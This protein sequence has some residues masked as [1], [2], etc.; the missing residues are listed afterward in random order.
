MSVVALSAA[1]GVLAAAAAY[2]AGRLGHASSRAAD[3]T[4]WLG[5]ALIVIPVAHRLLSRKFLAG[6]EAVSLVVVLT[7][8]E[9]LLKICYSPA[10]FTFVDEL[11]HWRSAVNLLHTGKLFTLNYMLPIS[12]RY[13]GLEEVTSALTSLTGLSVFASG[14]IVAGV[15]HL[16][17]VCLL[18][19]LFHHIGGRRLAGVAVLIYA[20]NPDLPYFDS[21]FAYQTLAVAFFGLALLAAWRLAARQTDGHLAGWLAVAILAILATV[22]THHATSFMLVAALVVVSAGSLFAGDRRS[23]GWLATLALVSGGALACWVKFVAPGTV[24]YFQPAVAGMLQGLHA[25]LAGRFFAAASTPAGPLGNQALAAAATLT[26]SVLLPIGWWQI[27]RHHRQ[28]P[29]IVGMAI[30]SLGWYVVVVI[31]FITADGSELAGRAA[32]FVFIPASLIAAIAVV[33]LIRAGFLRWRASIVAAAALVI[34]LT[35]LFDG[36]VN[37]WPPYWERLPGPYQVAGFER[38]VG[39]EEIATSQWTLDQLGPGNRFASDLGN[40]A[41]LGS[42]G[43]QNPL[44][45]VAYLYTSPSYTRSDSLRARA[46][47]IRYVLVDWRLARSLPADGKYFP[48][49]PQAGKYTHPLPLSDLAKF[50]RIPGIARVYDSGNIVIYDLTGAGHAP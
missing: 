36:L 1:T 40:Y 2:A 33:W 24:S 39:P 13:P 50:R 7:V 41:V 12:P 19:V 27:W 43:D 47:A 25:V 46:Q 35:L 37:G 45:D 8:A 48:V 26:M 6:Y 11:A 23:A 49:D 44:R 20:S 4:Y 29:W 5:Q 42:Y 21:I 14:L 9:Y 31:R 3:V 22:V 10:G 34:A 15:A 17:F 16:L 38:S 30:G 32:T 18:F 28:R